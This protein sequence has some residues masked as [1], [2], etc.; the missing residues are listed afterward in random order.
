[1]KSLTRS[2]KQ[3]TPKRI[4]SFIFYLFVFLLPWQTVFIL[5]ETFIDG[6][7][8]QYATISVYIFEVVLFLWIISSLIIRKNISYKK[9]TLNNLVLI[10]LFWSFLSIIWSSDKYLSTLFL[11]HLF[12]G[13]SMFFLLQEFRFNIKKVAG[14]FLLSSFFQ[15]LL[16]AYQ[17]FTQSIFSSKWLGLSAHISSQ[18]GV[19]VLENATGRWLRA[20]GGMPHPNMLG[21]FLAIS[22]VLGIFFYIKI[23]KGDHFLKYSSLIMISVVFI[24]LLTTFSRSAWLGFLISTLLLYFYLINKKLEKYTLKI[25]YLFIIIIAISAIF[26]T[27]YAELI[28]PRFLGNSRLETQSVSER[29]S[30]FQ[31]AKITIKNNLITGVGIGNYTNHLTGQGFTSKPIWEYQPVHNTP[32]LILS[33][34]GLIGLFI[35]IGILFCSFY[36]SEKVPKKNKAEKIFLLSSLVLIIFTFLFDHWVWTTASGTLIF[37]LLLGLYIKSEKIS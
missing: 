28:A 35:F 31:E 18:G 11:F 12:L 30:Y 17:F 29:I 10:F 8:F 13:I 3:I 20:Y 33:E 1:M 26:L 9:N 22:L 6:E 4:N 25:S 36:D 23:K 2:I 34:L 15:G 14:I 16:G 19:S 5:K 24:A 21:G 37:W 7:K 32:L 27:S